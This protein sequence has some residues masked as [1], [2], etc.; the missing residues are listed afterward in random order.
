MAIPAIGYWMEDYYIYT[1]VCSM[2]EKV[3]G[4]GVGM[5]AHARVLVVRL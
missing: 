3:M 1:G 5:V 2:A 4:G